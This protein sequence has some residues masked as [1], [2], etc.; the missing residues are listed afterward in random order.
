MTIPYANATSGVKARD[1]ITKILRGFGCE[2]VG[3][4]DEFATHELLLAFVHRNRQIQLR[5]SA[6]GWA[7]AFLK[8]QPWSYQRR[9]TK[10]E[11]EAKAL[12]QGM[13][14]VNS[15]L[16]D[17]IKSQITAIECGILQFDH[18]FMPY[19]L[20]KDGRSMVEH[21]QERLPAIEDQRG[22]DE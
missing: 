18:V 13:I 12:H 7:S 11:Y 19:M 8:D 21:M 22:A 4:M 3:F 1:E 16:R 5:A 17:W 9:S 15:I 10:A 14:A 2:S 6:S 20:A